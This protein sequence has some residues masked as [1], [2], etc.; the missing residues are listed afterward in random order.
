MRITL[1]SVLL[2][3]VAASTWAQKEGSWLTAK[4]ISF[5]TRSVP[6]GS[7]TSLPTPIPR[8]IG[9]P[10]QFSTV[11]YRDE[12]TVTAEIEGRIYRLSSPV[13]LEPGEYSARIEKHTVRFLLH[14]KNGKQ[15]PVKLRV[16]SVSAKQGEWQ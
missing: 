9:A 4:V 3:S 11:D 16:V 6:S 13:P 15:K 12:I 8:A 14:D 5:Q 2:L 7:S 1:I 10:G